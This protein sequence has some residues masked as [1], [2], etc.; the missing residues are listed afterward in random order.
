MIRQHIYLDEYDIFV[1]AYYAVSQYYTNEIVDRLLDIGCFGNNL[2]Q[3]EENLSSGELDTGLTFY[4]PRY[5]EAVM[6]IALTSSA[7]EFFNSLMHELSHL[8]AYI[9]KDDG[10]SFTGEKIAYLKGELALRIFPKVKKLLCDC[11]RKND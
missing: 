4:S 3:A 11:C 7:S 2:Q 5:R 10:L 8:T 9:A 1:H 6:V